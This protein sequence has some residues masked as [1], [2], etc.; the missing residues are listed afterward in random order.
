VSVDPRTRDRVAAELRAAGCVFAEDETDLLLD[1]AASGR[2]LRGLVDARVAGAPL[3]H[4]LGWAQFAGHRVLVD[5]GVFVPRRRTELLV[6]VAAHHLGGEPG[7]VVDLCCGSGAVGLA[8]AHAGSGVELHGVDSDP[9]AVACARRNL[10]GLG[11]VHLGDLVAPLPDRLR[12]RV[13]VVVACPPY[14][15]TD[16]VA[17]MPP[18]ARDHE[19]LGALDGGADGMDVARRIAAAAPDWL[20]GTGLVVL[21]TSTGQ[22]GEVAATLRRAGLAPEVVTDDDLGAT[23]V[24]GRP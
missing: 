19:P 3:E 2:D 20:T 22:A 8:V 15:P 1:T 10:E 13:E 16:A 5:P 23:A 9:V 12:G 4:V 17:L 21:E 7:V 11:Q 18:E 24:V 14:V 6:R